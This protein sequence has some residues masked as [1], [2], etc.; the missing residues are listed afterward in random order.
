MEAV[1][2]AFSK[3]GIDTGE[4]NELD[5]KIK[6]KRNGGLLATWADGGSR[7]SRCAGYSGSAAV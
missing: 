5:W 1:F 4:N 6:E 7:H 3:I 2:W